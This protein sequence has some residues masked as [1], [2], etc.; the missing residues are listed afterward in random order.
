MYC[1]VQLGNET[2][3]RAVTY[4]LDSSIW[5]NCG[6]EAELGIFLYIA[7]SFL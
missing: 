6:Y 4:L 2:I 1:A 5:R 7:G 3:C